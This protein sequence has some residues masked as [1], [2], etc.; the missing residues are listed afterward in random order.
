MPLVRN[1]PSVWVV[2][3]HVRHKEML[4]L[5]GLKFRC[6]QGGELIVLRQPFPV[7]LDM[8]AAHLRPLMAATLSA[9]L[10]RHDRP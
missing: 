9:V 10:S 2:L 5:R 3:S 6:V 1:H 8:I 7:L 4:S